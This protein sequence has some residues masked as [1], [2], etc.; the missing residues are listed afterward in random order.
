MRDRV[1]RFPRNY[2]PAGV[3]MRDVLMHDVGAAMGAIVECFNGRA[4]GGAGVGGCGGRQ[5]GVRECFGQA[6]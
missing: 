2:A 4:S 5:D 3:Y 1:N 6:K